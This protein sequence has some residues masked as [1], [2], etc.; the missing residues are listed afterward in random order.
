MGTEDAEVP[1]PYLAAI[2]ARK[3]SSEDDA[4]TLRSA[5]DK[6]VRAMDAGAW[7]G[8]AADGFYAE[9]TQRRA[10]ART[11]ADRGMDEF[12]HAID[13]IVARG[14]EMVDPHSWYV[15]WHNLRP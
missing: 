5:L 12:Q 10:T 15:H 1:N 14:D 2:R 11:A 6:A 3:A 7:V 8:G 4:R 13:G 9:L